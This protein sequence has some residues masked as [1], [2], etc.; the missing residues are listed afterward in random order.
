MSRARFI[1][2][3]AL[4][5]LLFVSF[6]GDL[7]SPL[8]PPAPLSGDLDVEKAPPPGRLAKEGLGLSKVAA[9]MPAANKP[10]KRKEASD[11]GSDFAQ[12]PV[13]V[14]KQVALEPPALPKWR[15]LIERW[16]VCSLG[17]LSSF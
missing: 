15:V 5:V 9:E 1:G 4:M 7:F 2:L 6:G 11:S 10:F 3:A 8:G 16:Y 17:G 12:K 13:G 14:A